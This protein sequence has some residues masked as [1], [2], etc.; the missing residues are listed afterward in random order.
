MTEVLLTAKVKLP[1]LANSALMNIATE[2][3]YAAVAVMQSP[4][5]DMRIKQIECHLIMLFQILL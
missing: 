4:Q 5:R 1:M 2:D 3:W